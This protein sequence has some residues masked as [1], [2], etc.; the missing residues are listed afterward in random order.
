MLQVHSQCDT[1]AVVQNEPKPSFIKT[2]SIDSAASTDI[3]SSP[4]SSPFSTSSIA[5]STLSV[6][7]SELSFDSEQDVDMTTDMVLVDADRR[8]Y[9]FDEQNSHFQDSSEESEK[10]NFFRVKK[11]KKRRLSLKEKHSIIKPVLSSSASGSDICGTP[12]KSKCWF[13]GP[14]APRMKV[15]K[16]LKMTSS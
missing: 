3:G 9:V 15:P 5:E 6:D 16:A 14:K 7:S 11:D 4:S 8:L 2:L 12:S 10:L 1:S 13:K